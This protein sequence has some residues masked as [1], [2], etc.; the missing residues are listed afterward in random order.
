MSEFYTVDDEQDK[1]PKKPAL[2]SESEEEGDSDSDSMDVDAGNAKALLEAGGAQEDDD[3][4]EQEANSDDNH[5]SDEDDDSDDDSSE[6]SEDS[7]VD[8]VEADKVCW[9]KVSFLVFLSMTLV[10]VGSRRK[11]FRLVSKVLDW[12]SLIAIGIASRRSMFFSPSH[13]LFPR[14]ALSRA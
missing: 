3:S 5:D 10:F 11:I 14:L 8:E 4:H 9:K 13:H 2:S 7:L 12:P 1:K 6:E